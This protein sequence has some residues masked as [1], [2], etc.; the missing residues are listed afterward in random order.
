MTTTAGCK[1]DAPELGRS[2]QACV[3]D[4]DCDAHASTCRTVEFYGQISRFCT[5]SCTDDSECPQFAI[6]PLISSSAACMGVTG[7][8]ALDPD[9][10]LTER[11]CAIS[12]DESDSD[13]CPLE[14]QV[15]LP[16]TDPAGG[17]VYFCAQ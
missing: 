13:P 1:T 17:A 11:I 7:S 8:G 9:P 12:C 15:C 16:A 6:H 4:D 3:T 10:S 14:G 2:Y 5:K